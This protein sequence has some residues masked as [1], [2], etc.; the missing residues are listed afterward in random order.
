[1]VRVPPGDGE[2]AGGGAGGRVLVAHAGESGERVE[3]DDPAVRVVRLLVGAQRGERGQAPAAVDAELE[4][5][6]GHVA[7]LLV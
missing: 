5:R 4:D 6:T 1:M 2:A 3:A 7:D